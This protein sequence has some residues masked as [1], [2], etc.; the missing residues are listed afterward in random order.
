MSSDNPH[1][2]MDWG[3]PER[4][5]AIMNATNT[6][7]WFREFDLSGNAIDTLYQLFIDDLGLEH[8]RMVPV[9]DRNGSRPRR[10]PAVVGV[11]P[12]GDDA[13]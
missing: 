10:N 11:A 3:Q 13:G 9:V 8:W 7:A 4:A 1:A 2:P 6:L 5:G 12:E